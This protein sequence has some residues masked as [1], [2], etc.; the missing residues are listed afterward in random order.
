M[1]LTK[2]TS[3]ATISHN[4]E[5]MEKSGHPHEQAV[6][7]ALHTAHPEGGKA[8]DADIHELKRVVDCAY[9]AMDLY[10]LIRGA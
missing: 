9:D 8:T 3:R 7:A 6:A 10:N 1:P 2:G 4:I 5:E